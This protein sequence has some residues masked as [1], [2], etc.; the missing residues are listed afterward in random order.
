MINLANSYHATGQLDK[1]IKL[2]EETR[3]AMTPVVPANNPDLLRCLF[4]LAYGYWSKNRFADSLRV[5]DDFLARADPRR[6]NPAL[7]SRAIVARLQ[8]CLKLGD[9]AG[10]RKSAEMFESLG[11]TDATSLYNAACHRALTA[12]L[13]AKS[14]D[15][16]VSRLAKEDADLAMSWLKKAVAAGWK[17][18]AHIKGIPTS[19][20]SET[21][22]TSKNWLRNSKRNPHRRRRTLRRSKSARSIP[23]IPGPLLPSRFCSA[24]PPSP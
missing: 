8:C 11:R 21:A 4:N 13:E 5:T 2:R 9:A 14:S 3:D 1:A 18:A 24:I 7:I 20:S 22:T 23:T 10:C 12:A 15:Q 17:D 6:F 16:T 19:I